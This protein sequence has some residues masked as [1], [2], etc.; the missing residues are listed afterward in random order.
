M[1]SRMLVFLQGPFRL[2]WGME[3]QV[4]QAAPCQR[5][6]WSHNLPQVALWLLLL[7]SAVQIGGGLY[8]KRVVIPAWSAEVHPETL[9]QKMELSGHTAS[10]TRFWPFVSPVVFLLAI[11]NAVAAWRH[12]GPARRWWLSGS[13]LFIAMSIS[14]YAYFVP[15]MLDFMHR[16][17]AFSREALADSVSL[18]LALSPLRLVLGLAGWC[19]CMRAL[20][21]LHQHGATGRIR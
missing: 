19:L 11:G 8:E 20:T 13:A 17:A 9:Q 12:Q 18:W 15:T 7:W 21:L 2:L 5:V 3:K 10:G 14:T 16:S 1:V 4:I 6:H